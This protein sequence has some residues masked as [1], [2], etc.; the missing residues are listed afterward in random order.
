MKNKVKDY[1][2]TT[3]LIIIAIAIVALF[4]KAKLIYTATIFEVMFANI[5]IHVGLFLARKF[6]SK[7]Q[8]LE[9]AVELTSVLLSVL[10]CGYIFKWFRSIPLW[11]MIIM[12]ISIYFITCILDIAKTD[13]DINLINKQLLIKNKRSDNH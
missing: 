3:A 12:I 8:I 6:N 7:Y 13:R 9:Y 4:F 10:A 11:I 2:A 5:V 1:L